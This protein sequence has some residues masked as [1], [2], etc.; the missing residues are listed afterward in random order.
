MELN[1]NLNGVHV[2]K[3]SLLPYNTIVMSE[4]LFEELKI[5]VEEKKD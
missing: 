5:I 2:I 3:N 1:V 4:D